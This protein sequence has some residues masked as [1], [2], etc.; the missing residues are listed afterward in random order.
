MPD[1]HLVHQ[2]EPCTKACS[3]L[4]E[5]AA[6]VSSLCS[7]PP[8]VSSHPGPFQGPQGQLNPEKP[9]AHSCSAPGV[10]FRKLASDTKRNAWFQE[11]IVAL[12]F[13][14]KIFHSD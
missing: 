7:E 11:S 14:M 2:T 10:C 8:L 1:W 4:Q 3:E 12:G 13:G 9:A 6:R 5:G